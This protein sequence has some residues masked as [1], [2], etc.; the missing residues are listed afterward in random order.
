V[1]DVYYKA[2]PKLLVEEKETSLFDGWS[3]C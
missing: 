3:K 1:I 2:N